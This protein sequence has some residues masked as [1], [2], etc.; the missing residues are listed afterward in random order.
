MTQRDMKLSDLSLPE[1]RILEA[2]SLHRYGEPWAKYDGVRAFRDRA[3]ARL[4][5]LGLLREK[6]PHRITKK[7]RALLNGGDKG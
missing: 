1:I 5:E 7:G 2:A 6:K 3:I 4:V